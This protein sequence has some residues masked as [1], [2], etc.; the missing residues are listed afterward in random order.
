MASIDFTIKISEGDNQERREITNDVFIPQSAFASY[1]SEDRI[2]VLGRLEGLKK[3]LKNLEIFI[4]VITLRSGEDW[5]NKIDAFI[6]TSDIFYLFWSSA[7]AKSTWVDKEWRLALEKKGIEF[8]DPFPLESPQLV[9]PP[10]EL[11]KLHFN[12]IYLNYI[13][14]EKY[15][16]SQKN[17]K[18]N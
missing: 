14:S 13:N 8:I 16:Q 6:N 4:D 12:S 1:A 2:D 10:P 3:G 7:A 15:I 18:E 11:G 5:E 9:P 17:K